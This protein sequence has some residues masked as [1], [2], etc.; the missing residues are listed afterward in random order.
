VPEEY[1]FSGMSYLK[2]FV[3]KNSTWRTTSRT[4][5]VILILQNKT[6]SKCLISTILCTS[7]QIN[8]SLSLLLQLWNFDYEAFVKGLYNTW[9]K[10]V[11]FFLTDT[12]ILEVVKCPDYAF[13]YLVNNISKRIKLW[14]KN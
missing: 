9:M 1:C 5:K 6:K 2:S 3:P 14:V 12:A 8:L 11:V 4:G 10:C 13:L 7:R